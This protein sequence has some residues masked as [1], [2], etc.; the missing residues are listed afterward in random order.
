MKIENHLLIEENI[1]HQLIDKHSGNFKD[2]LNDKDIKPDIILL[3]IRMPGISGF[4]VLPEIKSKFPNIKVIMLSLHSDLKIVEKAINLGAS[5]Y[6]CKS[7]TSKEVF[8]AIR[9]VKSF[10]FHL[11]KNVDFKLR[12]N[13]INN[14]IHSTIIDLSDR[15]KKVLKLICQEKSTKQIA[16]ELNTSI[17]SIEYNRTVLF[18][19]TNSVS[20]VGLVYFAIENLLDI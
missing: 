19:K 11:D 18:K 15:E 9:Q 12:T 3:D 10:D 14:S 5:G 8:N 6:L 13:G 2:K 7:A 16:Y 1:K 17:K 20:V 4:D